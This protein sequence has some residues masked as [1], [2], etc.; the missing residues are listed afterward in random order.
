MPMVSALF[1]ALAL[2]AA[3]QGGNVPSGPAATQ[4]RSS[5]TSECSPAVQARGRAAKAA[6][7]R[8]G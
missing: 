7:R 1:T 3:G 2:I 8:H 5:G 4:M 6:H